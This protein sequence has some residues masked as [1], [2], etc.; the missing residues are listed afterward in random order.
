M[1]VNERINQELD[2]LHRELSQLHHYST[3]IGEAKEAATD[4]SRAAQEFV[5]HYK[6]RVARVT[7]A[8]DEAGR[9]FSNT[10]QAVSKDFEKARDAF[11]KDI[12]EAVQTFRQGITEASTSL[13]EVEVRLQEAAEQVRKMSAHLEGMDIP[14]QFSKVQDSLLAIERQ[15]TAQGSDFAT[16]L[17]GMETTLY[18]LRSKM[19]IL[20]YVLILISVLVGVSVFLQLP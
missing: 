1:S 9:H 11:Q 17:T 5:A 18:G 6:E 8:L 7:Q 16:R 2:A 14:G 12:A 20:V 3:Q 13:S 10:T 15:Q 4:V 19:S